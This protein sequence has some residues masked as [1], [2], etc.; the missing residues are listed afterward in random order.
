MRTF[1]LKPEEGQEV[2]DELYAELSPVPLEIMDGD[3][4]FTKEER[5][6]LLKL[7]IYNVGMNRT[8][9]IIEEW[10]ER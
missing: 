2:D 5:E 1:V 8:L 7:L 10:K 3:L 9:E 6:N 4:S